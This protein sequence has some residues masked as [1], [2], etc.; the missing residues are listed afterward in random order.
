ML[1]IIFRPF[2][3]RAFVHEF[4]I[5]TRCRS[6]ADHAR[7]RE[8]LSL[9]IPKNRIKNSGRGGRNLRDRYLVLEKSL[10]GKEALTRSRDDQQQ[11]A[12]ANASAAPASNLGVSRTPTFKGFVV[13]IEPSPPESDGVVLPLLH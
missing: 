3:S 2:L 5:I 9:A 11:T 8:P 13:P 12:A 6:F 7:S 10:R 4:N 1:T